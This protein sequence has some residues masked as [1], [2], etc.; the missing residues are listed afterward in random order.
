MTTTTLPDGSQYSLTATN[1]NTA[2]Q[3]ALMAKY[4]AGAARIGNS[5][6][7]PHTAAAAVAPPNAAQQAAAEASMVKNSGFS[8]TAAATL[9][10]SLASPQSTSQVTTTIAGKS[11]LAALDPQIVA[12][13]N[14]NNFTGAYQ[15]AG[16]QSPPLLTG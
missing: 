8:P 4:A 15:L 5:M 16:Q 2:A 11:N 14:S 3:N 9:E 1:N 7:A 10:K 13:L 6:A 12:D